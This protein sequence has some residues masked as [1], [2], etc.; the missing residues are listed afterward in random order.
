METRKA[1]NLAA[2]NIGIGAFVGVLSAATI[3]LGI[4]AIASN[5]DTSKRISQK[6][7]QSLEQ[8]ISSSY[9]QQFGVS[10][11][12]Y[13]TLDE[14][15][16]EFRE[17]ETNLGNYFGHN[18][19]HQARNMYLAQ[20]KQNLLNIGEG[21]NSLRQKAEHNDVSSP[22]LEKT[23]YDAVVAQQGLLH[24]FISELNKVFTADGLNN[25]QVN[26]RNFLPVTADHAYAGGLDI[27]LQELNVMLTK[28]LNNYKSQGLEVK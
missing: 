2:L 3:A 15:R 4:Y 7:A 24:N 21:L 27:H 23:I 22:A 25:K 13:E 10:V 1:L 17:Y 19:E 6:V 18:P 28:Q 26:I 8:T 11:S 14:V 16:N 20:A 9:A 5:D 12:L